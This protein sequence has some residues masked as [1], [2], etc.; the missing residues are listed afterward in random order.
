MGDLG[1]AHPPAIQ[2]LKILATEDTEVTEE[3]ERTIRA[4]VA[5]LR[6]IAPR[7]P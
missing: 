4:Y 7:F 2:D 5:A 1:L 6:F 3:S